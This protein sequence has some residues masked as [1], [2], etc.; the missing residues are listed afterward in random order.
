MECIDWIGIPKVP[1]RTTNKLSRNLDYPQ[2]DEQSCKRRNHF[3]VV[4]DLNKLF[5]NSFGPECM[6]I[7]LPN[8][9]GSS[10]M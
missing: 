4:E 7:Y 6:G 8:W 2:R 3:V 9:I 1:P 5:L 10:E